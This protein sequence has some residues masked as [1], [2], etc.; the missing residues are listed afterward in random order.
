MSDKEGFRLRLKFSGLIQESKL[1]LLLL[2]QLENFA[3][4][5]FNLAGDIQGISTDRLIGKGFGQCRLDRVF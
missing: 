2:N 1:S 3:G 5:I 4:T